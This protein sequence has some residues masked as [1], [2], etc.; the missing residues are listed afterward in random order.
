MSNDLMNQPKSAQDFFMSIGASM[1]E[2]K[3][4]NQALKQLKV[5]QGDDDNN[6]PEA[7]R[8]MFLLGKV[9]S[10]DEW[11]REVY[12]VSQKDEKVEV[13]IVGARSARTYFDK[14]FTDGSEMPRCK[15]ETFFH[16]D[17]SIE[18]PMN[19]TCA[20]LNEYGRITAV[21]PFAKFGDP[22][23][24]TGKS[25]APRCKD[26]YIFGVV[27]SY[28]KDGERIAE[29]VELVCKSAA[30]S[31][32]RKL[33]RTVMEM[34]RKGKKPWRYPAILIPTRTDVGKG[35]VIIPEIDLSAE[36]DFDDET[37]AMFGEV[38]ARW[39][40]ALKYVLSRATATHAPET[41]EP[42]ADMDRPALPMPTTGSVEVPEDIKTFC[43]L[44]GMT[45][46]MQD[47]PDETRKMIMDTIV[48]QKELVAMTKLTVIQGKS[49]LG[50]YHPLMEGYYLVVPD[51]KTL[52]VD[53]DK[54]GV[55]ECN[56]VMTLKYGAKPGH[57]Y[58]EQAM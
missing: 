39:E 22:D 5:T 35:Y 40:E 36:T 47:D 3:P 57:L 55:Y 48:N 42:A 51:L 10:G 23:P 28:V 29:L 1:P 41:T 17:A 7:P 20:V 26:Q 8:S 45:P 6:L 24:K 12:R 50:V 27:V 37:I 54:P 30:A 34:R 11:V 52:K 16:P 18:V 15:S 38:E 44:A 53:W 21:C 56:F 25:Q 32:G 19:D 2:Y 49:G 31:A 13:R 9:K 43:E 4:N 58:I 14:P 46:K 33:F